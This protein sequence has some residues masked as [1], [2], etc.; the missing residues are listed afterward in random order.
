MTFNFLRADF[1]G[2]PNIGLYGFATDDYCIIGLKPQNRVFN[3]LKK[4]LRT[5]IKITTIA[6]TELIGL[7]AAGNRN[8]ILVTKIIEDYEL[9]RLKEMFDINIEVIRSKETAIG[10]LVLCNDNGCLIS[11]T[12]K[13]FKKLIEDTLNCEVEI[14][15]VSKLNIV[16]STALSNNKGCLC[17]REAREKEMQ[18]IEDILKVKVDVGT[19][20]YGSPFVKAGVI[21]NDKGVLFSKF[22]TGAELGRIEEVFV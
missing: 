19:V 6:G 4:T 9:K 18:K 12:L 7:F 5:E 22:S 10:N 20:N 15:K 2:D 13:R 21:V 17:H 1:N 14:G 11:K 8:G 3:D 16:G